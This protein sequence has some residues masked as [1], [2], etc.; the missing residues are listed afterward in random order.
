MSVLWWKFPLPGLGTHL[1]RV[2]DVGTGTQKVLLDGTPLEAPPGT[3]TFTGPGACFLELQGAGDAWSLLVDGTIADRYIPDMTP[4]EA[5]QITWFKFSLPALGTHHVRVTNIGRP[6]QQIFLDGA[7]MAAPEGTTQFTGPGGVLL[8]LQKKD[9]VWVLLIDGEPVYQCN[10][11]AGSQGESFIWNFATPAGTHYMFVTDVGTQG[12]QVFI[13]GNQV[14]GPPGQQDFTGPGG[15]FLQLQKI[16][17]SWLLSVDGNVLEPAKPEEIAG[18]AGVDMT[19][20]FVTPHSGH[21][22][23]VRVVNIGRKGQQVFIDGTFIPGPDLQTAFTGPGGTLLELKQRDGLWRLFIDG[24]CIE[25]GM[26]TTVPAAAPSTELQT[27]V[28][29]SPVSPDELPQGVSFDSSSGKYA[30]SIRIQG[31]FR[32]LGQF[33]TLEEAHRTYLEAKSG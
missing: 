2:T 14:H 21:A 33:A 17:D 32:C 26:Q 29:R 18:D 12:Q 4:M 28:T 6:G 3:L 27:D 23:Q 8:E 19:W 25:D 1:L 13:D 15:S 20:S 7:E 31:K 24:T 30:A 16:D 11:K 9:C 10:P 22:H 5:P